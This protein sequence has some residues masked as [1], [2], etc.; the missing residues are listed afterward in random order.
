MVVYHCRSVELFLIQ[1]VR[2]ALRTVACEVC[3]P[4]DL[5]LGDTRGPPSTAEKT[6][7]M[8]KMSL[9]CILRV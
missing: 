5:G 9:E 8:A 3:G 1:S 7:D 2:G 6:E 4:G